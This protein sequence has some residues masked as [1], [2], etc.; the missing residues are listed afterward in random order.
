MANTDGKKQ[1][2][3]AGRKRS[4]QLE[5]GIVLVRGE[6]V[7]QA[8][9]CGFRQNP[10][11]RVGDFEPVAESR[12]YRHFIASR[13]DLSVPEIKNKP[14][15]LI[16]QAIRGPRRKSRRAS[17]IKPTAPPRRWPRPSPTCCRRGTRSGNC[18]RAS[19]TGASNT[20]G[21]PLRSARS[22]WGST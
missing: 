10:E 9:R 18:C 3:Q 22:S 17:S 4:Q 7:E 20:P 16:P 13:S 1:P 21:P 6:N 8:A 19:S 12:P 5:I 2:G 11:S 15:M 14:R